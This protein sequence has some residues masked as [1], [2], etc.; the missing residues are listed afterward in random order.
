MEQYTAQKYFL[1][2]LL[3]LCASCTSFITLLCKAYGQISFLYF[4]D[5][6]TEIAGDKTLRK[7][8]FSGNSSLNLKTVL[9]PEVP[10]QKDLQN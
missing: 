7:H 6:K 2:L 4:T 8:L 9:T 1:P 10:T 3:L 5:Y